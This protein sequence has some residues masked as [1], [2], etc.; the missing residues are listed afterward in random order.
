MW[1]Q[2][3]A[4]KSSDT[5]GEGR[6]PLPPLTRQSRGPP[7]F[8]WIWNRTPEHHREKISGSPALFLLLK[9]NMKK[10]ELLQSVKVLALNIQRHLKLREA[11]L[12]EKEN[13]TK[14]KNREPGLLPS[15]CCPV[16]SG[17][18]K[19]PC[20]LSHSPLFPCGRSHSPLSPGLFLH[21]GFCHQSLSPNAGTCSIITTTVSQSS[22]KATR[23]MCKWNTSSKESQ[24]TASVTS[25]VATVTVNPNDS[26]AV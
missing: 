15:H 5:S 23:K 17:L 7:A 8:W 21:H 10:I 26:K 3:P 1:P 4:L 11:K 12:K 14:N 6:A 24:R 19:L 25:Q 2:S 22:L 16:P 9:V 18:Q 13:E 20:G